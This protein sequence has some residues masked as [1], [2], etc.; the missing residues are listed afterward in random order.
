MKLEFDKINEETYILKGNSLLDKMVT[1]VVANLNINNNNIYLDVSDEALE[2]QILSRIISSHFI[3]D[4]G[5]SN[6]MGYTVIRYNY[7]G[8]ERE[9]TVGSI[10]EGE[11]VY[12]VNGI[13]NT[14]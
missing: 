9:I 8:S 1:E 7:K 10:A 14:I 12:Y 11:K 2:L 13:L 4:I 6:V 3:N 5:I